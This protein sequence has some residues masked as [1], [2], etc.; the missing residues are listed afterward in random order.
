MAFPTNPINGQ[1]YKKWI[2]NATTGAWENVIIILTSEPSIL[3]NGMIW[4]D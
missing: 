1:V 3:S 4:V 2:F